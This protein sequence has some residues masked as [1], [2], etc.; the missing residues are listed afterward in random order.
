M[1]LPLLDRMYSVVKTHLLLSM[2]DSTYS[3][4]SK[5][6]ILPKISQ[7]VPRIQ[8]SFLAL[9]NSAFLLVYFALKLI[10][11]LRSLK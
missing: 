7:F 6:L 8:D 9:T 10:I 3:N 4:N 1:I 11:V 2:V 5:V